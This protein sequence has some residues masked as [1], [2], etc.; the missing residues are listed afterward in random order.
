MNTLESEIKKSGLSVYRVSALTG[1]PYSTLSDL[2]HGKTDLRK[3]QA[4]YLMALSDA[5]G[6]SPRVLLDGRRSY[7]VLNEATDLGKRMLVDSIW[8]SAGIEG[9]A[10]TFPQTEAILENLPVET[11]ADEVMFLLNMKRAWN[12]LFDNIEYPNNLMFIREVSRIAM[13]GILYSAG[14]IRTTPVGIGGTDWTPELPNTAVIIESLDNIAKIGNAIDAAIEMFCY[15]SRTQMFLDGNKRVATLM[16][17][18]VLMQNDV[19]ILSVPYDCIPEFKS[20]LLDFYKSNGRAAITEFFAQKCLVLTKHGLEV[21]AEFDAM[22]D[23][24]P[25]R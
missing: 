18:K 11:S 6:V 1:V 8:K 14:E 23:P 13:S 5:L 16:A 17:N 20:L 4:G 21:K 19:G 7:K 15:I 25:K 22:S 9:L 10:T 24:P 3:T 12:F 2:V